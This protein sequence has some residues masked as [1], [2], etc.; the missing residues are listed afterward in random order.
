MDWGSP[1]AGRA[2]KAA[3]TPLCSLSILFS[4]LPVPL[5]RLRW[6]LLAKEA[7]FALLS[8]FHLWMDVPK[9]RAGG[10]IQKSGGT[11][12]GGGD[13]PCDETMRAGAFPG[14]SVQ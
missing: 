9:G 13:P 3:A 7:A 5:A 14:S 6:W 4:P 2:G 12:S 10:N 11:K 1:E 8:F